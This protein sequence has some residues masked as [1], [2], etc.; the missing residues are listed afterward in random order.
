M[1]I[2]AKPFAKARR[3]LFKEAKVELKMSDTNR[4]W[5]IQ[6]FGAILD[7]WVAPVVLGL[8]KDKLPFNKRGPL[9]KLEVLCNLLYILLLAFN[10]YLS[11]DILYQAY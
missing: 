6:I 7:C 10:H 3:H 11:S 1:D 2:S 4:S 5:A 9:P 8:N